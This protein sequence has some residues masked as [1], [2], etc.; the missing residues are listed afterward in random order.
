MFNTNM[1]ITP[2]TSRLAL[3]SQ[4]STGEADPMLL[5]DN[6]MAWLENKWMMAILSK[7]SETNA[8]CF[9]EQEKIVW[10]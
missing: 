6:E 7:L 10:H 2:H 5:T 9:S 8:M 3:I 4:V 1:F